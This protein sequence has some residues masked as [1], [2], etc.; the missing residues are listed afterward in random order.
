[1]K[2]LQGVGSIVVSRSGIA[3]VE[4][5]THPPL[6]SVYAKD[7]SD[8]GRENFMKAM[9]A[10][11]AGLFGMSAVVTDQEKS[12]I[13]ESEGYQLQ[14]DTVLAHAMPV[15][16]NGY[17]QAL[18]Q[19]SKEYMSESKISNHIPRYV[20][21]IRVDPDRSDPSVYL[22]DNFP[23][24]Y[25]ED[26]PDNRLGARIIRDIGI[27][28]ANGAFVS[29]QLKTRIPAEHGQWYAS[30][31]PV[32]ELFVYTGYRNRILQRVDLSDMPMLPA[33]MLGSQDSQITRSRAVSVD[34][35]GARLQGYFQNFKFLPG[36]RFDGADLSKADL[37]GA[38]FYP[39][40][41]GSL[42]SAAAGPQKIE[43]VRLAGDYRSVNLSAFDKSHIEF[44]SNSIVDAATLSSISHDQ[45]VTLGFRGVTLSGDLTN[46]TFQLEQLR[47]TKLFNA[48]LAGQ[49]LRGFNFE[50]TQFDNVDLSGTLL[51]GANFNDA[52]IHWYGT[53]YANF[54]GAT[55]D[56]EAIRSMGDEARSYIKFFGNGPFH[57]A[58]MIISKYRPD[59]LIVS[60]WGVLSGAKILG[61]DLSD[62]LGGFD[63]VGADLSDA[64]ANAKLNKSVLDGVA[65]ASLGDDLSGIDFNDVILIGDL[66]AVSPEALQTAN[67]RGAILVDQVVIQGLLDKGV[68]DLRGV[69]VGGDLSDMGNRWP[70]VDLRD[71]DFSQV[72]GLST[73]SGAI[74]NGK[75]LQ[76]ITG[77]EDIS[78][79]ILETIDQP[80]G[81][82]DT[83]GSDDS[84][85]TTDSLNDQV[86]DAS[87]AALVEQYKGFSEESS[88]F[89][90]NDQQKNAGY[91]NFSVHKKIENNSGTINFAPYDLPGLL[92][93]QAGDLTAPVETGAGQATQ[94]DYTLPTESS[95]EQAR[96]EYAIRNAYSQLPLAV[97]LELTLEEF[98]QLDLIEIDLAQQYK[99]YADL[100]FNVTHQDGKPPMRFVDYIKFGS[101][102]QAS[103]QRWSMQAKRSDVEADTK[104]K[105]AQ[106]YRDQTE[107]LQQITQQI[108][109]ATALLKAARASR[110]IQSVEYITI[111]SRFPPAQMIPEQS[112]QVSSFSNNII[113]TGGAPTVGAVNTEAENIPM[114]SLQGK[115][116]LN[117]YTQS[118]VIPK[119][120]Y[121]PNQS[122]QLQ[123][124]RVVESGQHLSLQAVPKHVMD[125]GNAKATY[126]DPGKGWQNIP[127]LSLAEQN[128]INQFMQQPAFMMPNPVITPTAPAGSSAP[129]PV[130]V[131]V[132]P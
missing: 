18:S 91:T 26:N 44:L 94:T 85:P 95:P 115:S 42:L 128:R 88:L 14:Y 15:G 119:Y 64:G 63:L 111:P 32:P 81:I 25:M 107:S 86:S 9:S 93:E 6:Q 60:Q 71:A 5:I 51:Q 132:A 121:K 28:D 130:S 67:L 43:S 98:R 84:G 50:K 75:T 89:N 87:S 31:V 96:L 12:P 48:S 73:L 129:A 80:G 126:Y 46:V 39:Q 37:T 55:L 41:L 118:D 90:L 117:Q 112:N 23:S 70:D 76:S 114:I 105:Q 10:Q 68:T 1:M 79:A 92:S 57:A 109:Q 101:E 69:R 131:P 52:T 3:D 124:H 66:S 8:T 20:F 30:V 78:D 33:I 103:L 122:G 108:E 45:F 24:V 58:E 21:L 125:S 83:S 49:D 16:K 22:V 104:L 2:A 120:L 123:L 35:S 100:H 56:L 127:R 17:N 82:Q 65:L 38:T 110:P 53:K 77:N 102:I 29:D 19:R 97:Q 11:L 106:I 47:V 113:S 13:V 61:N 36:F 74:V 99:A 59:W 27:L 54:S 62:D 7:F 34:L 4:S 72:L 40:T 116:G